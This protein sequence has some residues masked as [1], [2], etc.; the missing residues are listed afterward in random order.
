M[1]VTIE[2]TEGT[3]KTTVARFFQEALLL[4]GIKSSR[5]E[6]GSGALESDVLEFANPDPGE[7]AEIMHMGRSHPMAYAAAKEVSRGEQIRRLCGYIENG[8]SGFVQISQDDATK[9]WVIRVGDSSRPSMYH[10]ASFDEAV[11]AAYA[12][13]EE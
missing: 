5:A 7:L 12:A 9:D 10:G 1:K 8:T 13:L 11:A 4:V 3:G 6:V 2:G